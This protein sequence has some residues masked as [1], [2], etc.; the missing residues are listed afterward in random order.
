[1]TTNV[2]VLG[3]TGAVGQRF[4]QL[5]AE[6]PQFTLTDVTASTASAGSPYAEAA[7]WRLSTPLPAHAAELPVVETDPA[8]VSDDVALVF[9][10]LPSGVAAAVEPAFAEAGYIVSSNASN[11]RMAPDVPL[12]IPEV[13]PAH[14][15]LLDV[16][17]DVRGTAGAV[18]KNPN[19][20]T[21]TMVPTL[22]A[23]RE[24]GL[25]RVHVVTLQAVSGAGYGG[26]SS[27]QILDNVIPHISGEGP[28]MESE[29]CKL[30]GTLDGDEVLPHPMTVSAS[31]NRVPTIDG[32]LETVFIETADQLDAESTTAAMELFPTAELHSSPEPVIA[33][34]DAMDR[35]QPRLDRMR[36]G[37]MQVTVGGITET[38]TGMMYNCL[39][40]NTIRGAAGASVLNGELLLQ[41]GYL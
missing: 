8:A 19:C 22:A 3:A 36:G 29:S 24:A 4:I 31:T 34:L 17:R 28:K 11:D 39:A 12:V 10:A 38:Q 21:I 5:L 14:L 13:N 16:Q 26:V 20:S 32:H 18:L 27:M 25:E 9:S 23:V 2:A 33:V 37:G 41:A 30:L 40:H 7:N 6:H 35:P 15:G 1:M